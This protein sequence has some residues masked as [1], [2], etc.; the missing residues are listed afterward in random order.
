MNIR[1]QAAGADP[2]SA[3][4]PIH[5]AAQ[6]LRGD[7]LGLGR[8]HGHVVVAD[9]DLVGRVPAVACASRGVDLLDRAGLREDLVVPDA[10]LPAAAADAG[11][12]LAEAVGAVEGAAV[13]GHAHYDLVGWDAGRDVV[14]HGLVGGEGRA[15]GVGGGWVKV[16]LV[17]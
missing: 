5:A 13:E 12:C 7:V 8:R 4:L 16:C 6:T 3:E 10:V 1:N 14:C 2:I 9:D 17:A 11:V 15:V